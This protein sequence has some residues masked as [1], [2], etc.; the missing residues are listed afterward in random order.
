MAMESQWWFY[1][2]QFQHQEQEV[3]VYNACTTV[4]ANTTAGFSIIT[5]TGRDGPTKQ[6]TGI[7]HLGHGLGVAPKMFL[8]V[9]DRDA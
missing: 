6:C 2:L 8:F 7:K 9:N 3:V 5:Y 1:N 4:Q